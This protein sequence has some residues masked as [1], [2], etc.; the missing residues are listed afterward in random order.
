MLRYLALFADPQ[1]APQYQ[2]MHTIGKRLANSQWYPLHRTNAVH[3]WSTEPADPGIRGILDRQGVVIG[4]IFPRHRDPLDATA[5]DRLAIDGP[6]A[7]RIAITHGA[8][9][10]SE[11]WGDYVAILHDLATSSTRIIKDP[12]GALPCNLTSLGDLLV[13]FSSVDD[14][15]M[16]DVPRFTARQSF[17]TARTLLGNAY[18]LDPPL[19]EVTPVLRGQWIEICHRAGAR[20]AARGFA[21]YP[22]TFTTRDAL[23]ESPTQ[24]SKCLEATIRSCTATWMRQYTQPLLRL[25]G[26]LDSSIIAACMSDAAGAERPHSYTY[27]DPTAVRDE[28]PWALRVTEH[29]HLRHQC[30]PMDPVHVDLRQ[31]DQLHPQIDPSPLLSYL[32]RAPLERALSHELGSTALM[33][34]LGGD[35]LFGGDAVAYAPS[36]W[37]RYHPPSLQLLSLAAQV[38]RFTQLSAW[39]IMMRALRRSVFGTSRRDNRNAMRLPATLLHPQLRLQP[40]DEDHYPHPWF[41]TEPRIRWPIVRRL[42]E[43]LFPPHYYWSDAPAAAFSPV[44]VS[45]LYSQPVVELCLRIPMHLHFLN[46]VERGLARAAFAARLPPDI[47]GRTWKDRAP[48]YAEQILSR[49]LPYLRERLLEGTLAR[50]QVLDRAVVERTLQPV[51]SRSTTLPGELLNLLELELWAQH[52]R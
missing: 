1:S 31:L 5:V 50:S 13:A 12:G 8:D 28:R 44:I 39:T 35:S 26:G 6:M 46:G 36:E 14:I 51:P 7:R 43:L 33:T 45:P 23:I 24:A 18:M 27:Y 30:R 47:I 25:S 40:V 20:I 11:C 19:H 4:S 48:G 9:L 41:A 49:N 52:W 37:L 15:R 32:Q 10:I 2:A 22:Q 21:W 34:G 16:L 17:L 29:L 42:G 3:V 38:A